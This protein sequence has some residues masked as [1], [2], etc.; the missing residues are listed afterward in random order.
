MGSVIPIVHP[1]DTMS[2]VDP[3]TLWSLSDPRESPSGFLKLASDHVVA[4]T[5]DLA[6][7][8]LTQSFKNADLALALSQSLED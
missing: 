1:P 5:T 4:V 8:V 6:S 7:A 2:R 3:P